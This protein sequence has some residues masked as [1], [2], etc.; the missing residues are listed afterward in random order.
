MRLRGPILTAALVACLAVTGVARADAPA[1]MPTQGLLLDNAGLPVSDGQYYVTF[2]LYG[3]AT[4]GAPLWS[5]SWPP[6]GVDCATAGACVATQGG[7][8]AILMGSHVPLPP[9]I[10]GTS[11]QLWLGIKVEQD[12][13]LP[14]S[15]VATSAYAFRAMT[16][17]TA[18]A[19]NALNCVGCIAPSALDFPTAGADASGGSALHALSASDLSCTGCVS[20]GEVSF[21]YAAAVTKGGAATGL[22]CSGCVSIAELD[23]QAIAALST[24]YTDQMAVAA[25][26]DAG[27]MRKTDDVSPAQLPPD[28]LN[29]V[30]NGALTTQLQNSYPFVGAVPIP[31]FA[32]PFPV[33]TATVTVPSLGITETLSIQLHID[34]ADV[35]QLVVKLKSP[36]G[37]E[38]VLHD[39]TGAGT[40]TLF[41]TYPSPSVPAQGDLAQFLG[42][43]IGGTWTLEVSDKVAGGTGTIKSF[44]MHVGV[45]SATQV[46]V[47]GSLDVAGTLTVGG[48]AVTGAPAL[49]CVAATA[50]DLGGGTHSLAC[51]SGKV[52]VTGFFNSGGWLP[53]AA[54]V[55]KTACTL[56]P[57]TAASGSC[58]SVTP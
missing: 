56:A 26:Q 31:D 35:G 19:A 40:T 9:A 18:D 37:A 22:E 7:A 36:A 4:G 24:L 44:W 50:S 12:P 23:D 29:E 10:F 58:C 8:F 48:K 11:P 3:A 5:E 1:L 51:P 55:G 38:L 25:V 30:S 15:R 46:A 14:R 33:A 49:V 57:A 39:K 52:M 43:D 42:T 27:F 6:P 34:H 13:E 47:T 53:S 54:C 28:G 45:L 32:P 21:P 17:A 16:A 2:S 41:T 20:P